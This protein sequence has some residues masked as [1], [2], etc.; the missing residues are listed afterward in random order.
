M[1]DKVFEFKLHIR[2]SCSFEEMKTTLR[3]SKRE[4]VA[5]ISKSLRSQRKVKFQVKPE[6][7]GETESEMAL[8]L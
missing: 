4:F 2:L 6:E 1:R 7:D 8:L 5:L 3:C